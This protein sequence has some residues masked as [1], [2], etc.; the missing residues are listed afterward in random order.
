[1]LEAIKKKK[2]FYQFFRIRRPYRDWRYTD[3]THYCPLCER[4]QRLVIVGMMNNRYTGEEYRRC[5]YCL[6]KL[7]SVLS[8]KIMREKLRKRSIVGQDL[9]QY[10]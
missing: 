7:P 1:M 8:G 9:R 5:E 6:L 2:T 4:I 3:L 10:S